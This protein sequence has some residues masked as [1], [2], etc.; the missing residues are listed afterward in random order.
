MAV[1]AEAALGGEAGYLSEQVCAEGVPL[2]LLVKL[3]HVWGLNQI[4]HLCFVQ[5]DL[6]TLGGQ[7]LDTVHLEGSSLLQ[8][9]QFPLLL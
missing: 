5:L 7:T 1:D 3:L 2:C 6:H 8:L 4:D 9:A